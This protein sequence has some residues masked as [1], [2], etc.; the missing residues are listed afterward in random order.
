MEQG[1]G[2][3]FDMRQ[4]DAWAREF[5]P[6]VAKGAEQGITESILL[7]ENAV[8]SN[9]LTGR[10]PHGATSASG[11]LLGHVFSE[12]RGTPAS[13]RGIVAVSPP[14]DQYA[15]VVEKGRT[16]GKRMPPP[17]ALIAWVRKRFPTVISATARAFGKA[18]KR[19]TRR[20]AR[21]SAELSFAWIVAR[22]IGKKGFPGI[23]MFER[24]FTEHRPHVI[25]I[26]G[27]RIREAVQTARG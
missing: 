4:V 20:Q 23:H 8:K 6:A 9:I 7:L 17:Q 19:L 3:N 2:I 10:P 22:S 25:E 18:E 27:A 13:P 15:L 5:P 24:A 11:T 21:Q 14:A 1:F 16:P 12:L 26:I